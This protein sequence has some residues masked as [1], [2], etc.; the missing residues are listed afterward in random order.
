MIPS[1]VQ[2]WISLSGHGTK[3]LDM[4]RFPNIIY[5]NIYIYAISK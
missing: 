4:T 5:I 1:I 3:I 2:S